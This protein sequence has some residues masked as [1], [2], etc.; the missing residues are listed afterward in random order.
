[1]HHVYGYISF[2]LIVNLDVRRVREAAICC[3]AVVTVLCFWN[4]RAII[5]CIYIKMM[6]VMLPSHTTQNMFDSQP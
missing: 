2:S 3:V 1:M 4:K 6:L 5:H